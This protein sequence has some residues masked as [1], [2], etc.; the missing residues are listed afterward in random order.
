MQINHN[1]KLLCFPR[2]KYD[3][4]SISK[5]EHG[6]D[7]TYDS[8]APQGVGTKRRPVGRFSRGFRGTLVFGAQAHAAQLYNN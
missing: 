8:Y 7:V 1:F 4:K 6:G 5:Q 2:E 3:A